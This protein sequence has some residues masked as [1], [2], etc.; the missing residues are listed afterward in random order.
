[1]FP[2][3]R[4]ETWKE[5]GLD[6][7]TTVNLPCKLARQEPRSLFRTGTL[8]NLSRI[9]KGKLELYLLL[10]K[11]ARVKLP[12]FWLEKYIHLIKIASLDL[13]YD[14]SL[15]SLGKNQKQGISRITGP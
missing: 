15:S 11:A 4:P 7:D 13:E 10:R 8:K 14:L 6:E 2:T 12:G 1:M 5:C 3:D 9:Q